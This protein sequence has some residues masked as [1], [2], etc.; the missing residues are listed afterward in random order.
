MDK[1]VVHIHNGVLFSH[2][3]HEIMPF[4]AIR[5]DLEMIILNEVR[6]RRQISYD[7]TYIC[8]IKY[9]TNEIVK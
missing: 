7:I 8:N 4:A 6:K 3:K 9:D 2:K 1:D 5:M